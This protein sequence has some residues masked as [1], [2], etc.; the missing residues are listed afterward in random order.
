MNRLV[1]SSNWSA[2]YHIT[3]S[4]EPNNHEQSR[5]FLEQGGTEAAVF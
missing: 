4:A 1:Q 2:N 3:Y 5:R